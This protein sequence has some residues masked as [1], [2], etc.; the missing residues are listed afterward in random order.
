[1]NGFRQCLLKKSP[2]FPVIQCVRIRKYTI[3]LTTLLNLLCIDFRLKAQYFGVNKVLYYNSKFFQSP[4]FKIYYYLNKRFAL[5]MN[6]GIHPPAG[7]QRHL[8][9]PAELNIRLGSLFLAEKKSK[10]LCTIFKL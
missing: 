9:K 6:Y 2:L 7:I 3:F 10:L 8:R 4:H 1:M 5:E